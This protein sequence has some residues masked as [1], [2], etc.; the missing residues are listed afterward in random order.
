MNVSG[1]QNYIVPEK[2]KIWYLENTTLPLVKSSLWFQSTAP[3]N[4]LHCS[5]ST[6]IVVL[7]YST[8]HQ[9][10]TLKGIQKY[11]YLCPWIL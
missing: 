6:V 7:S 8:M 3:L 11:I 10:W 5:W 4:N 1:S 2:Y 9:S